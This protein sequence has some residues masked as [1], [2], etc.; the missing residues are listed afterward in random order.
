MGEKSEEMCRHLGSYV[1]CRT[2]LLIVLAKVLGQFAELGY[3]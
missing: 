2:E 1:L 3:C